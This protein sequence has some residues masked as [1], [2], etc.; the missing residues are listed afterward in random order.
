ME[1]LPRIG[2]GKEMNDSCNFFL[3]LTMSEQIGQDKHSIAKI[4]F[5]GVHLTWASTKPRFSIFGRYGC[6]E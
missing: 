1:F 4:D 6:T 2:F 3:K 5:L